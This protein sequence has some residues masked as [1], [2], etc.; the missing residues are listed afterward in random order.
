MKSWN[1]FEYSAVEI[2]VHLKWALNEWRTECEM[3]ALQVA[4]VETIRT[5]TH[6]DTSIYTF[7]TCIK[8]GM[9]QLSHKSTLLDLCFVELFVSK[10]C[11]A[12]TSRH[13]CE[14]ATPKKF[15]YNKSES[16]MYPQTVNK[17]TDSMR[18]ALTI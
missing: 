3:V 10:I 8:F 12:R 9:R 6:T 5:D 7:R 14:H 15:V 1:F 18:I 11:L 2:N 4:G 16:N 17:Q 13:W